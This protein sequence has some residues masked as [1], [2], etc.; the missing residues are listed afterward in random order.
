MGIV[1]GACFTPVRLPQS[2]TREHNVDGAAMTRDTLLFRISLIWL[3]IVA[4]GCVYV[5]LRL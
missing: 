5:L 1:A 4:S 3:A 2:A